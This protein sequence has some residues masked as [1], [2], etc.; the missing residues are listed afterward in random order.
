[1]VRIRELEARLSLDESL[2]CL[3]SPMEPHF[4]CVRCDRKR[5]CSLVGVQLLDIAQQNDR[6]VYRREV[7]RCSAAPSRRESRRSRIVWLASV[8]VTGSSIHSPSWSKRGSKFSIGCSAPASLGPQLHERRVHD[9]PMKPGREHRV[10]IEFV[11]RAKGGSERFL[12]SIL[13]VA[14]VVQKSAGG[15]QHAAA[16]SL[17]HQPEGVLV[18]GAQLREQLCFVRSRRL[19]SAVAVNHLTQARV[20]IPRILRERS[21]A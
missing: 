5:S 10:A 18:A 15:R 20:P 13:R 21:P 14:L 2:E 7:S 12:N 6:T 16:V 9:D 3:A 19:T 1:M 11:E 4:D 17:N 8:Q